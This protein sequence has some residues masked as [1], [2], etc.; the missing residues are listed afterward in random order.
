MRMALGPGKSQ[1]LGPALAVNTRCCQ[2]K[3]R[4]SKAVTE[5]LPHVVTSPY[6]KP[7]PPCQSAYLTWA[8]LLWASLLALT[9]FFSFIN[10]FF[11]FITGFYEP[12]VCGDR[13]HRGREETSEQPWMGYSC[14]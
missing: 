1:S 12:F 9:P 11:L 10:F 4:E 3:G 14:R 8:F 5:D 13:Q 6:P 7:V 2:A